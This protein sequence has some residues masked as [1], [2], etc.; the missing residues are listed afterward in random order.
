MTNEL[1]RNQ[2]GAKQSRLLI[3]SADQLGFLFPMLTDCLK[4]IFSNSFRLLLIWI[5][6]MRRTKLAFQVEVVDLG[7]VNWS[8]KSKAN[9]NLLHSL[10]LATLRKNFHHILM[11]WLHERWSISS[12]NSLVQTVAEIPEDS[13]PVTARSMR[14]CHTE[15]VGITP[16]NNGN[17][18]SISGQYIIT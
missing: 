2:A 17:K 11:S 14:E 15:Y 5:V 8:K 4:A 12:S 3:H 18:N 7:T 10:L 16:I 13:M 1:R 6:E 9:F